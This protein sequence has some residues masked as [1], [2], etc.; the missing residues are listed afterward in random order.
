MSEEEII[1][2][3]AKA[4]AEASGVTWRTGTY[5]IS[6]GKNFEWEDHDAD[7][8]NAH[9]RYKAEKAIAAYRSCID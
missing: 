2:T 5:R 3:V 9:W 8:L 6:S 7:L 1:E 4:I